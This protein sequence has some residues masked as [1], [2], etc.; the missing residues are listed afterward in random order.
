M[1]VQSAESEKMEAMMSDPE[2]QKIEAEMGLEHTVYQVT[3][4]S[5]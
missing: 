2:S 3:P 1:S 5:A 4:A